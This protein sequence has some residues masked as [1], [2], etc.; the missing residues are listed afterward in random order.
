MLQLVVE[1]FEQVVELLELVVELLEQV[2]EL[3]GLL[4]VLLELLVA[5]LLQQVLYNPQLQNKVFQ[6]IGLLYNKDN[7]KRKYI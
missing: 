3:L 6:C 5:Q 7:I 1:L 2:V 4:V